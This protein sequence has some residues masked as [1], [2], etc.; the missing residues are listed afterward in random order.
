MRCANLPSSRMKR[1]TK[2]P[3]TTVQWNTRTTGSQ[4]RISLP[5][6]AP[7]PGL[8]TGPPML[9]SNMGLHDVAGDGV[10][11]DLGLL[12]VPGVAID[13]IAAPGDRETLDPLIAKGR[14]L[15]LHGILGQPFFARLVGAGG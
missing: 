10:E 8:P 1:S 9:P 4:T 14:D 5:K 13:F 7:S 3:A 11:V 15:G 2:Q 12:P 6:A